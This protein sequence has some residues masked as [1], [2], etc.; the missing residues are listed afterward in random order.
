MRGKWGKRLNHFGDRHGNGGNRLVLEKGEKIGGMDVGTGKGVESLGEKVA[1]SLLGCLAVGT[2]EGWEI[3]LEEDALIVKTLVVF[4]GHVEVA[5]GMGKNGGDMVGLYLLEDTG[6]ID[7]G[8]EIGGLDEEKFR[9]FE[10][11]GGLGGCGSVIEEIVLVE[12]L[13]EEV[14]EHVLGGEVEGNG[15]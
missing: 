11:T 2:K 7:W 14:V 13:E 10:I 15:T 4:G 3:E 9:R 5:L 1:C 12:A 6:E 8:I